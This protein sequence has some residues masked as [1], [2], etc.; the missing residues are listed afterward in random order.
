MQDFDLTLSICSWNTL[1]DLRACLQSLE[2]VRD[3]ARFE[4]IVADNASIDGSAEMVQKEFPWV[5]LIRLCYNIGFAGGHNLNFHYS[6]GKLF[7]PLNSD[8]IVHP[9]AIRNIVE[10]MKENPPVGVLGPKLLNPDGSLQFSCRRFPTPQA[11][12]FRNTILG[13]LFPKNR[14]TR[15]Y[16]MQDWAHD[17]AKDVDWVS[18]AAIC[19]RRE[20]FE[21]LG[22]FD[23]RFFM[24]LEDVDLCYRTHQSNYRVVYLPTAVITHAIG[25]S[26]DKAANR[27]I[28]QFHRS[29]LLFYK[30]HYMKNVPFVF[31]PFVLLAAWDFLFLRQNSLI[32]RNVF[33]AVV[34]GLKRA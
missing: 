30:K 19:V 17:E 1:E 13:K 33:H 21:R 27:M 5:R 18:G 15:E 3:E 20:V 9:H 11:A 6:K 23:E 32:L 26:T 14:Y 12:L 29:M 34:R 7:M 10:F 4:V 24:Y 8:T 22:G 28:R 25:R 31:R 2:K 16:L